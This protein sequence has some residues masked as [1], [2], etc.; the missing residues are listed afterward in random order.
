MLTASSYTHAFGASPSSRTLCVLL[1]EG[2]FCNIQDDALLRVAKVLCCH[3]WTRTSQTPS[4]L[5]C[6]RVISNM[7][8]SAKVLV[9]R[10]RPDVGLVVCVLRWY[11]FEGTSVD[12][13]YA[14]DERRFRLR[15]RCSPRTC[16]HQALA[17]IHRLQSPTW[18]DTGQSLRHGACVHAAASI[19]QAVE[20]S[21][22]L[23]LAQAGTF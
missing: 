13:R 5:G 22:R 18:L 12:S 9:S 7:E 16:Q 8:L 2:N 1:L 23:S 10:R 14:T 15:A 4:C 19:L 11:R 21:K 3:V 6:G 17:I 20:I